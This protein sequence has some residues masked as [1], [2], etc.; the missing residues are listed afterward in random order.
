MEAAD[1]GVLVRA[2]DGMRDGVYP[3]T[4][5]LHPDKWDP[6]PNR[7]QLFVAVFALIGLLTALGGLL[8]LIWP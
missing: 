4:A 5:K 8:S 1:D 7:G 2:A 6:K 3:A